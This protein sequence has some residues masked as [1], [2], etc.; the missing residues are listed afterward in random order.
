MP[1][2][3][4]HPNPITTI[5]IRGNLCSSILDFLDTHHA[6]VTISIFGAETDDKG[7]CV[8]SR[9]VKWADSG[10]T[11]KSCGSQCPVTRCYLL[12]KTEDSQIPTRQ[13]WILERQ[14]WQGSCQEEA[15]GLP[16]EQAALG[17]SKPKDKLW[18]KE[19]EGR[20]QGLWTGHLLVTCARTLPKGFLKMETGN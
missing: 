14:A 10:I 16:T 3:L 12:A 2:Q 7:K 8:P 17:S 18:W 20:D 11:V 15:H 1:F 5:S 13:P 9:N 4:P 6:F 19:G